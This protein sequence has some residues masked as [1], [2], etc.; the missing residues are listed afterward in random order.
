MQSRYQSPPRHARHH[1][2]CTCEEVNGTVGGV[3]RA[4][5]IEPDTS[6][7]QAITC[8]LAWRLR[9]A[10]VHA[11]VLNCTRAA[12]LA[13]PWASRTPR[14]TAGPAAGWTTDARLGGDLW[15]PRVAVWIGPCEFKHNALSA[16]Y[17]SV[18]L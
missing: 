9:N 13:A 1:I 4:A 12:A 16:V 11:V 8:L 6:L 5:A 10:A 3:R 14:A 2:A 7:D 17:R 18:T 15:Y